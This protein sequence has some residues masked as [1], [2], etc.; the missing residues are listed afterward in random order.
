MID[1]EYL[2]SNPNAIDL[3]REEPDMIEWYYLSMNINAIEILKEIQEISDEVSWWFLSANPGIF[4]IDYK[5]IKDIK[6][7]LNEQIIEKSLHPKRMLRL[8]EE[9]GEDN[10]YNLYFDE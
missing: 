5:K 1:W 8:M 3:L 4:E 9:Y 7:E 6:K 2:S 10:I